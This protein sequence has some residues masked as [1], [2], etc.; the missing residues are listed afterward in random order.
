MKKTISFF[1]IPLIF[2]IF[3]CFMGMGKVNKNT[4]SVSDIAAD[5][6]AYQGIIT[7][8]GVIAESTKDTPNIFTIIETK[9]A[10]LCKGT[11]CAA[12]HL[13][14]KYK[15]G[16]FSKNMEVNVT[17]TISEDGK[18]LVAN[19]IQVIKTHSFSD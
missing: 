14:V 15:T 9:E 10:V 17:G 5:P 4:L 7:V 12:F 8:N 2:F 19:N 3:I 11:H 18:I 16:I 6:F 13:P 1:S